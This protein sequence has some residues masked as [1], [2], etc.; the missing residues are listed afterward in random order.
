LAN[1]SI[2]NM[3]KTGQDDLN[4]FNLNMESL[5]A[6][7]NNKFIAFHKRSVIDSDS[8]FDDLIRKLRKNNVDTSSVF[9]KFLSK[10]KTIL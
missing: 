4:W 7:Y 3:L 6:E 5:L 10:V 9:I 2:I 1:A 8:N